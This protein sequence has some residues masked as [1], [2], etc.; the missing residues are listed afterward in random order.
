MVCEFCKSEIPGDRAVK[1][2]SVR[3][4]NAMRSRR[5]RGV[6]EQLSENRVCEICDSMFIPKTN[7]SVTCSD[8][9]YAKLRL[10]RERARISKKPIEVRREKYKQSVSNGTIYRKYD[11]TCVAHAIC[12][13]CKKHHD[14]TMTYPGWTGNGTPR[15]GCDR[16][17]FCA[18]DGYEFDCD[19]TI[20]SEIYQSDNRAMVL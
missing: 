10:L 5:F 7:R 8:E 2:C 16:Y 13:G 3:C 17:P 9:C 14:V 6:F 12:P 15:I 4:S 18:R 1:Y 19:H 20:I 11:E